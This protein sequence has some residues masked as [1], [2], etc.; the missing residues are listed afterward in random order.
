MTLPENV[1][2]G[3]VTGTVM[4]RAG[5]G[6]QGVVEFNPAPAYVKDAEADTFITLETETFELVDGSFEA[7]L[8]ATDDEDL[9]PPKWTYKVTFRFTDDGPGIPAFDIDVPEG[10][11]RDLADIAPVDSSTGTP[12][13]R[14]AGVPTGGTTGQVL[15]KASNA[16]DDTEWIDVEGVTPPNLADLPDVNAGDVSDGET[17]V[18]NEVNSEWIPGTVASGAVSWGNVTNKP[19]EIP[20]EAHTHQM[21]QVVDLV[22][23]IQDLQ[24]Q[25]TALQDAL[26]GK[27]D[28]KPGAVV[29]IAGT[30]DALPTTDNQ[31]GDLFFIPEAGV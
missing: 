29:R 10:T 19:S 2:T 16:N 26:D 30:G 25:I 14:G 22:T 4:S 18:W 28:K 7:E 15:A 17:L 1:G 12:I 24:A 9:N 31:E 8:V 6:R 3:T 21:S 11:T 23:T 13:V 20:P 27:V 5:V